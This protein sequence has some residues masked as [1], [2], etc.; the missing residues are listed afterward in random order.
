[1]DYSIQRIVDENNHFMDK[2]SGPV[3]ISVEHI[4]GALIVLG[5]GHSLATL[6][7]IIEYLRNRLTMNK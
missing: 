3:P 6:A 4:I 2:S 1:M 5:V 7:F